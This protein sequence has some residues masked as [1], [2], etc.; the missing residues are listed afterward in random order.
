MKKGILTLCSLYLFLSSFCQNPVQVDNPYWFRKWIKV[1]PY[2]TAG[3]PV[4]SSCAG[5]LLYNSDSLKYQYSDGTSWLNLGSGG[6]GGDTTANQPLIAGIGF[7]PVANYDGSAPVTHD[8]DTIN[9][10]ATKN[11][12]TQI[13]SIDSAAITYFVDTISCD[14]GPFINGDVVL[15]CPNGA[16]GAFTAKEDQIA[17]L[18]GGIWNFQIATVGQLLAVTNE[19][20]GAI[21][22]LTDTGWFLVQTAFLGGGNEWGIAERLGPTDAFALILQTR[23]KQRAR[24]DKNGHWYINDLKG[25]NN[26][27]VAADSATGLLYNVPDTAL[28]VH[29]PLYFNTAK[30]SLF[31]DT[32]G[33]GGDGGLSAVYAG[34]GLL[35]VNDST[36]KVDTS[37]ISTKANVVSLLQ[38]KQ[39]QLNGTGFVKASGTTISYDNSTYLTANQNIT[40]TGSGDVAGT[41]SGT[42]SITPTL[43]LATVN[44]NI[45]TFNNVTVNGKGLVTAASNVAYLTS[46]QNIV[47]TATGDA[48]GTSTSSG[49]APSL[50]LVLATVNSN[51]GTFGSGTQVGQFT[52]NGKGLITAASNVSITGF[53]SSTLTNTH[54]FV[55]NGSNVATDV[56][57]SGDLN[58]ANTGTFTLNTVNSNVGSFTSA[59]ITVDAKGRITAAASGSGGSGTLS[60]TYAP[61]VISGDTIVRRFNVLS[62]GADK[63]GATDATASIQ[64]AINAANAAGGGDVIFPNGIYLISGAL[65]TNVGGINMNS[66]IYIP[67]TANTSASRNHIRLVGESSPV[68][69]PVGTGL[70]SWAAVPVVT[71]TV[72]LKSSL[73]S[74]ATGAAVIGTGASSGYNE[75]F[76][77]VQNINIQVKNN[78]GSTGAPIGGI[79]YKSGAS[80]ICTDVVVNIDTSGFRSTLPTND[81][82]G[83]ET[84]DNSSETFNNLTNCLVLGYRKGYSLGEHVLLNQVQAMCCFYGFYMKAGY[85]STSSTHA[86]TYWCAYDIYVAGACVLSNFQ[87]D[88]E[89]QQIS[90]WYDDVNT[91]KDSANLAKGIVFYTITAAGAGNDNTKFSQ[92]G[93]ANLHAYTNNDGLLAANNIWTGTHTYSLM[94]AGSIPYFGTNGVMRQNNAQLKWD[95]TNIRLIVGTGGALVGGVTTFTEPFANF[96]SLLPA[97]LELNQGAGAVAGDSRF[98]ALILTNNQSSTGAL[99]GMIDFKN[100]NLGVAEKRL[101]QLWANTDGATNSGNLILSMNTAG[102]FGEKWRFSNAGLF[103]NTGA[104]GTSYITLKAGTTAA[105]TAPLG[106]TSGPV[107][108][109]AQAGK[110]EYTTPQLFF[111]N[112]GLQRQEIPLI[113]QTRVSTQFDKTNTTLANITGLTATLVAGKIYRF[114]AKLFTTSDVAGGVKFAIA[115]TATATNVIYEGLTTD[116]GLTTQSRGTSMAATVGA[117]TAVT[118]AYTEITGTITV[119]AAGTITVQ[120]AEN[121]AT[122]TSSILVGSTFVVTQ[123]P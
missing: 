38:G 7:V 17:S 106:F 9:T 121:A 45:G 55:G 31:I 47:V 93:G 63:T 122:A 81:V 88:A 123:M 102:T 66:Q 46:N 119:N 25:M 100:A 98:G 15:V 33:F 96:S 43:T 35:N 4:A 68:M 78:A 115:G 42:T 76:L 22:K 34:Y 105:N 13:T 52:V 65:Q 90:K 44:S 5:C 79:S 109:T 110:V 59:N 49:T 116:A 19:T 2:T 32:S 23:D 41:A 101:V 1:G 60:H 92:S 83:I 20:N 12:L 21:Y 117:V 40:W 103:S 16:T 51:V 72:I 86:G 54:L 14:P 30:D 112:D 62:Y 61:Y 118:N 73:T 99:I 75:T 18:I 64:A 113:Q 3:R 120:F 85:H 107:N 26:S 53:T 89:W 48:T 6:S 11:D 69:V 94:T 29:S 108:T 28:H 74:S 114:E 58:L 39:N 24:I 56:A 10:I 82:A 95:S 70:S 104:T 80:L 50:P 111:T 84:P 8:I 27:H 71:S 57:A 97:T 87:L 67:Y 77:T 37:L 91:I 36:L